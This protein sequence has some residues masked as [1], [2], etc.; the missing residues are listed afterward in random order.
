MTRITGNELL[1]RAVRDRLQREGHSPSMRRIADVGG[2]GTFEVTCPGPVTQTQID[3]DV[4]DF[5][6]TTV[7]R[8]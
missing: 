7:T 8:P 6:G 2:V 5:G 4:T 3:Q 1:L